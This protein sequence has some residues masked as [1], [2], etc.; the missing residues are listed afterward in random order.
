MDLFSA[1]RL[2]AQGLVPVVAWDLRTGA[3]L[4]LAYADR[5]ALEATRSTGLAHYHS[6]SRAALWKKGESSGNVQHVREIRVDCDGDAVLYAVVPHG[7]ACHTGAETCF[8]RRSDGDDLREEPPPAPAER[9]LVRL[10]RVI[11]ARRRG[12]GERSYVKS[13]LA[14][15][16]AVIAAKV[17]EEAAEVAAALCAPEDDTALVHEVADLWFHTLV[18]LGSRGLGPERVLD[19]LARRFGRSGLDEKASRGTE[20]GEA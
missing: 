13:L 19:E 16:P 3:V 20:P 8:F 4:M 1:L 9:V 15:G 7:P 6:R 10:A 5:A 14:G 17:T 2:D 18:A 12:E 11:E